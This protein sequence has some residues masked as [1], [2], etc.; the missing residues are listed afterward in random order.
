MG[1]RGSCREGVKTA[2][3][4]E[5]EVC[6]LDFSGACQPLGILADQFGRFYRVLPSS[7]SLLASC[8]VKRSLDGRDGLGQTRFLLPQIGFQ[9]FNQIMWIIKLACFYYK[10]FVPLLSTAIY[11]TKLGKL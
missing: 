8:K 7:L 10:H 5:N 3:D 4:P 6:P 11:L 2:T 9:L 1:G